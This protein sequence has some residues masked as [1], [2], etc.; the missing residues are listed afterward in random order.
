[1]GRPKKTKA[2]WDGKEGVGGGEGEEGE[3]VDEGE[4]E[5]GGGGGGS[6]QTMQ[7][8]G[9]GGMTVVHGSGL[10]ARRTPV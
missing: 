3:E 9:C 5:G 1:M 8:S 6:K 2:R 10:V 4:G 7:H